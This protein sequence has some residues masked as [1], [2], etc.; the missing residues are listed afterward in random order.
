MLL[1]RQLTGPE[2]GSEGKMSSEEHGRTRPR[3]RAVL[4]RGWRRRCPRCGEG[5]LFRRRIETNESCSACQLVYQPNPGDTLTFIMMTDRIPIL[6]GVIAV[7]FLGF[8]STNLPI[9]IAFLA[10]LIVP[11]VATLRQRQGL[12]LALVYLSRVYFG[13]LSQADEF[14]SS[15]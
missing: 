5:Q 9:T 8:R 4:G 15:R 10:A 11:I 6:F 14:A 7:Y 2:P 1:H 12:A 13:D 3:I